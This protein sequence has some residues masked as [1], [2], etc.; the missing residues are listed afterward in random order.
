MKQVQIPLTVV[1]SIPRGVSEESAAFAAH[2]LVSKV[3]QCLAREV[4]TALVMCNLAG[5]WV[6]Y[7]HGMKA[8]KKGNEVRVCQAG[9]LEAKE[10]R[11]APKRFCPT[12]KLVKIVSLESLPRG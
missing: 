5:T 3:R 10:E 7:P 9:T 2:D 6:I 8:Y 11:G 4:S 12:I 1:L